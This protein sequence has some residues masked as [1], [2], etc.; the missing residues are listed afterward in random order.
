MAS[1]CYEG[2]LQFSTYRSETVNKYSRI[3]IRV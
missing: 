3:S 2:D 1:A